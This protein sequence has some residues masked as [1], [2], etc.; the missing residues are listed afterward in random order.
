MTAMEVI[1]KA[2]SV[3]FTPFRLYVS[4]GSQYE[5]RHRDMIFVT[6]TR[7]TV[8]LH[9]NADATLPDNSI[10]IDLNHVLKMEYISPANV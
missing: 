6:A 8:G 9:S 2:R 3:S 4:D 10:D 1:N 5:I 7:V